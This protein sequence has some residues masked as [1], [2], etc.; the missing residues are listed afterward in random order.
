MI[1]DA[2]EK[3]QEKLYIVYP[4]LYKIYRKISSWNM[5]QC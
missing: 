1:G 2:K 3:I 4:Q 5:K